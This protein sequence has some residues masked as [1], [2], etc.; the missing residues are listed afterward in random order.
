ME[1]ENINTKNVRKRYAKKFV[2]HP[3]S[4]EYFRSFH[5]RY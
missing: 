5:V 2:K 1:A 4:F 3:K